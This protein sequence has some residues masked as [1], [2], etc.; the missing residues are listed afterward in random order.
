MYKGISSVQRKDNSLQFV[1][2][3]LLV[4]FQSFPANFL[5]SPI[6][7]KTL[8]HHHF[9]LYRIVTCILMLAQAKNHEKIQK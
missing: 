9:T 3:F 8:L 6:H 2:I 5:N 4:Q 1:K 7:H